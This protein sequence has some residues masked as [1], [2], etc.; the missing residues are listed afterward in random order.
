M[1]IAMLA[2]PPAMPA[3]KFWMEMSRKRIS[4]FSQLVWMLRNGR[5]KKLI[6]ETRSRSS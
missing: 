4:R 6:A 1:A 3:M 2:S 5:S